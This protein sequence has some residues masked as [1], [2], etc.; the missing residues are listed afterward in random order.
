MKKVPNPNT[1]PVEHMLT[2]DQ[3][4]LMADAALGPE[5]VYLDDGVTVDDEG[6]A[7]A[8][9]HFRLEIRDRMRG[10]RLVALPSVHDALSD[11][12]KKAFLIALAEIGVVG[13][14]AARAGWSRGMAYEVRRVDAEFAARWDEAIEFAADVAEGEA[15]RRGVK[16]TT[17]AI[18][19]KGIRCGEETVYSDRMLELTLKARRPERFR[20]SYKVDAD[21]K[22]GVLV[23]PAAPAAADWEA[24]AAAGQEQYR[25]G[26]HGDEK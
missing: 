22:G 2:D 3:L 8:N 6:Q 24:Q 18:Y 20:E 19:H 23:V 26:Q 4:D 12:R 10:A 13:Q 17:K 5:P 9:H 1:G 7:A 25:T 21:V 14:A 15:F 16:G 11:R